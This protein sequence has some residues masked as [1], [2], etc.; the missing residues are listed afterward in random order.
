MPADADCKTS[1][2]LTLPDDRPGG[3][4]A[5][6]GELARR[7]VNLSKLESRPDPSHESGEPWRYRFY[8]DVDGHAATPP[9]ADALTALQPHVR[10]LAESVAKHR[11][12]ARSGSSGGK[13]HH[14]EGEEI[15]RKLANRAPR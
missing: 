11:L 13:S 12:K 6:L 9:L 4:A 1:L 7:G 14:A 8:L 3:L 5:V 10:S 2:V 15:A